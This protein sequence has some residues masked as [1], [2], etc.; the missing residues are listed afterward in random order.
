[1]MT[2]A[3]T[4]LALASILLIFFSCKEISFKEP[5]PRGKKSLQQVPAKLY[6]V[7]LLSDEN[8]TSKD[9]L[10]VSAKGYLIVSDQKQ[11]FLGDSLVLKY[12][13]GYYFLN[14]NE[15]PEW[16]LRVIK[17]EENGDLTYMSM[18]VE[19]ASFNALVKK[20]SHDVKVD[21]LE[22]GG[23]KLYQIDPSPKQLMK[24]I[25]NGYFKKTIRMKKIKS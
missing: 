13:K 25:R 21:S 2:R 3:M 14:I 18:D 19:E 9:T 20:L 1:M 22:V 4:K 12:H 8:E 23:E 6:G 16:L 10:V 11:N 17:Q 24:L 15:N 7:Y 5:Q